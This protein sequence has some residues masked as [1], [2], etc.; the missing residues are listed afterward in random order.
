MSL[1]IPEKFIQSL[2]GAAGF[3]S[4]AF[5]KA[6]ESGIPVTS[7]RYN[8]LKT[9]SYTGQLPEKKERIGWSPY[10]YYLPERPSFTHDP[11]F[12]GGLYYVQEPGSQFV[13][14]A[15]QCCADPAQP[16]K[17]LDLCAAPGGKSTL[18]ASYFKNGLV[19]SNEIMKNRASVLTENVTKWGSGNIVV[20]SND[21]VH[22]QRLKGY[23]DVI[24]VD[25]PCSGSGLFRKEPFAIEQW[26]TE[27]VEQCSTRQENILKNTLPSLKEGGMV[28][29]STCSYSIREDEDI[30]DYLCSQLGLSP[31]VLPEVPSGVVPVKGKQMSPNGQYPVGYKF[32]PDKVRSEGFFLSVFKK[33][34][35]ELPGYATGAPG[36]SI[37]PLEK[38]LI[39]EWIKPGMDVH[40]FKQGEE[41]LAIENKWAPD[42]AVLQK[43]LFLKKA[44]VK[45]GQVKGKSLVP[46]HDLAVSNWVHPEVKTLPLDRAQ[47]L[48]Y[49]KCQHPDLEL[50]TLPKGWYLAQYE[51][52]RLGWLKVLQGRVNNYYP[53][54]WRIL[55]EE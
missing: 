12:H 26:T 23:F 16:V 45:L 43:N 54:N 4:R 33:D 34:F 36:K 2:E 27:L 14:K 31:I 3:D 9:N 28:I 7:V 39:Q 13:W 6:H 10:G 30:M 53:R 48:Q 50:D 46:A 19:V 32:Y 22:F 49:L 44:G 21:P 55:K 20:T 5:V 15:L 42:L 24:L 17:V 35:P 51:G 11:L 52:V 8:P 41:I 37:T 40:L 1:S 29:Y 47:S 18:L 25:A 38:D